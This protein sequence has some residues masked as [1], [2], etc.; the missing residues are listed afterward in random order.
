MAKDIRSRNFTDIL[1][2][3]IFIGYSIFMAY[4]M[5]YGWSRGNMDNIA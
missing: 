3:I 5:I 4:M 1:F 2:A